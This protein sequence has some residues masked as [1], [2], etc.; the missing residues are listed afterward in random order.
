MSAE[1]KLTSS[2]RALALSMVEQKKIK[3]SGSQRKLAAMLEWSIL[4]FRLYTQSKMDLSSW[5]CA[6]ELLIVTSATF[7]DVR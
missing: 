6:H 1:K 3:V 4:V 5:D 2:E 7:S